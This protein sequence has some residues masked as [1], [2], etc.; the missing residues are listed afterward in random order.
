MVVKKEVE[1]EATAF[2]VVDCENDESLTLNDNQ[3]VVQVEQ[4]AKQ[5]LMQLVKPNESSAQSG[6][7]EGYNP[8]EV[9]GKISMSVEKGTQ[10][11]NDG[12]IQLA[13]VTQSKRIKAN[14]KLEIDDNVIDIISPNVSND[15]H[16]DAVSVSS[17]S[18][19]GHENETYAQQ[20]LKNYSFVQD[21]DTIT[22][23]KN[24]SGAGD[25]IVAS[26]ERKWFEYCHFQT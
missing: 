19:S 10:K 9:D 20:A 2:V 14:I 21:G 23:W 16:L 24:N 15:A 11:R 25:E 18:V 7:D 3:Q 5:S 13:N 12:L 1:E 6:T 22:A 17:A 8:P 26:G 4:S